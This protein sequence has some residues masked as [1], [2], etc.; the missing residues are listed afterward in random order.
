MN[1]KAPESFKEHYP[2]AVHTKTLEDVRRDACTMS[3]PPKTVPENWP[4]N[5]FDYASPGLKIEAG[6]MHIRESLPNGQ[7]KRTEAAFRAMKEG[8]AELEFWLKSNGFDV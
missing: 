4:D 1:T 7:K 6:A 8:I 2:L 3:Y 5:I